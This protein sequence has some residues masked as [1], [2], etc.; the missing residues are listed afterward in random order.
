MEWNS[1]KTHEAKDPEDQSD[2]FRTN[3]FHGSDIDGLAVI[4]EPVAK[5]DTLYVEFAKLLTTGSTGD[6]DVQ[7]G[8]FNIAMTPVLAF[9]TR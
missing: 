1:P 8:I 7:K 4:T 2:S 5:V 3:V 9:N 6:E